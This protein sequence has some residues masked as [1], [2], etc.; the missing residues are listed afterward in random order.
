[1]VSPDVIYNPNDYL[2][3]ASQ[4][5]AT[6]VS[7]DVASS[8]TEVS[9]QQSGQQS[10][11]TIGVETDPNQ[12]YDWLNQNSNPQPFSFISESQT[13]DFNSYNPNPNPSGTPSEWTPTAQTADQSTALYPDYQPMTM[14]YQPVEHHWFYQKIVEN[15]EVW[16]PFSMYD[17]YNLEQALLQSGA[18]N[19][20]GLVI[21]TDG[22]RFDVSVYDRLRRPVYWSEV[23]T[24]VRRCSWFY[25]K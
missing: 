22:G 15:K 21:P 6:N 19:G 24:I 17:S 10:D 20:Y 4:P 14:P 3:T 16:L 18:A 9:Q 8:E 11:P 2:S 7:T 13:Q 25:K 23:D 5:I 1:M 12:A